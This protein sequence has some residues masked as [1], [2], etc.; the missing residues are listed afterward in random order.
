VPGLDARDERLSPHRSWAAAALAAAVFAFLVFA[1][2][3]GLLAA[4]LFALGLTGFVWR[5]SLA[6]AL[7]AY[8]LAVAGAARAAAGHAWGV[9]AAMI[10]AA[11]VAAGTV[12]G[13][14]RFASHGGN[15]SLRISAAFVVVAA[16][17]GGV[18]VLLRSLLASL[19][20]LEVA[21]RASVAAV[22]FANQGPPVP[23]RRLVGAWLASS[24]VLA[25]G[26]GLAGAGASRT[27]IAG[28]GLVLLG[29]AYK[30]GAV[31]LY[32]WMPLLLRHRARRIA[33][34]GALVALPVVSLLLVR[35]WATLGAAPEVVVVPASLLA[36]VAMVEGS[37]RALRRDD[38]R[39][40]LS[41][42]AVAQGG[43]VVAA[44]VA[45]GR[46]GRMAALG[47]ALAGAAAC[48][49]GALT[50]TPRLGEPLVSVGDL[51]AMGRRSPVAGAALTAA[52]LAL[53]GLVPTPGYPSRW[54]VLAILW[55]HGGRPLALA[56][57]LASVAL[58]VG[59]AALARAV[60][61]P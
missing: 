40:G 21:G 9:A 38:V 26:T 5:R 35:G 54:D 36:A 37:V 52:L 34:F 46:D 41:Y 49:V 30:L 16:V 18:A 11:L 43:I 10:G 58:G 3:G 15:S 57:A 61:A 33:L 53:A 47:A 42:A 7:V 44:L 14:H 2:R 31:P 32:A 23:S 4:G 8:A 51:G 27:A 6:G 28:S 50:L 19:A 13:L 48:G 60:W 59:A 55:E 20:A 22:A 29:L 56:I 24:A 45:G 12:V 39:C 1:Q 17:A 25:M